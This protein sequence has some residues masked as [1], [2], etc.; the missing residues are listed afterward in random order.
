MSKLQKIIND[1]EKK[2]GLEAGTIQSRK[3]SAYVVMARDEAAVK[4]RRLGLSTP[5]IGRL[6]NR[7]HTAI[8]DCFARYTK[9]RG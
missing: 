5:E 7:D 8:L 6:L 9:H 3:R 4:L 2:Y 1:V